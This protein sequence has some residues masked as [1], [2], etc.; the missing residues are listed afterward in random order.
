MSEIT[1]IWKP[2]PDYEGL[3][4]VSNTGKVRS[5]N[6]KKRKGKI[7][8]LKTKIDKYGYIALCLPNDGTR[9]SFRVHKLVATAFL[10]DAKGLQ[11]NHKDSNKTHAFQA[12]ECETI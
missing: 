2:I 4:E 1:E 6:Y 7:Q 10:G 9:K 12:Y 11:V 5:L 3:Y 8:L